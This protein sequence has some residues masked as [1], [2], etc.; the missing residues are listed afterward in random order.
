MDPNPIWENITIEEV[1]RSRSWNLVSESV[2]LNRG[3]S[4]SNLGTED[5]QI[6]ILELRILGFESW[7]GG[8]GSLD[9]DSSTGCPDSD[10]RTGY[11]D[12]DLGN[13]VSSR[14]SLD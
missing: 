5:P 14:Q 12:S 4:D 8:N 7:N 11:R 6:R 10:P 13:S 9:S 2:S 1:P 3:S